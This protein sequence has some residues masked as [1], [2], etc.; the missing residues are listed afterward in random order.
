VT[1]LLRP[2]SILSLVNIYDLVY[3]DLVGCFGAQIELLEFS[4]TTIRLEAAP[5]TITRD[6]TWAAWFESRSHQAVHPVNIGGL[7]VALALVSWYPFYSIIRTT[8][9]MTESFR[10]LR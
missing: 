7:G 4:R 1:S 6:R 10:E 8:S 5:T 2:S 3:S 9:A